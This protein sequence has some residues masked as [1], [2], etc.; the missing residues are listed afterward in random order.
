MNI[1]WQVIYSIAKKIWGLKNIRMAVCLGRDRATVGRVLSGEITDIKLDVLDIYKGLFDP[2]NKNSPA[3]E[4]GEK[5]TFK[6]LKEELEGFE[7]TTKSLNHEDYKDFVMGLL[8]LAESNAASMNELKGN[9]KALALEVPSAQHESALKDFER[10]ISEHRFLE[11]IESEPLRR[12]TAI[13]EQEA[14]RLKSRYNKYVDRVCDIEITQKGFCNKYERYDEG[15]QI[16][17]IQYTDKVLTPTLLTMSRQLV[18]DLIKTIFPAIGTLDRHVRKNFSAFMEALESYNDLLDENLLPKNDGFVL[19]PDSVDYE[20][21][22]NTE[23]ELDCVSEELKEKFDFKIMSIED[24]DLGEEDDDTELNDIENIYMAFHWA[25]RIGRSQIV[26]L[27][28][29]IKDELNSSSNV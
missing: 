24:I 18:D 4:H 14:N 10:V 8:L 17:N 6:R 21:N 9:K 16:E 25:T 1:T 2:D 19:D 26:A 15:S 23:D 27:Y 22:N 28:N 12:F 5:V 7:E 13:S 11:F 29:E 20:D 3:S